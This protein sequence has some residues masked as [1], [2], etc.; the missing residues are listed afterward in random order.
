[1]SSS[2]EL[3]LS[4]S[5]TSLRELIQY[6]GVDDR[7]LEAAERLFGEIAERA[8]LFLIALAPFLEPFA[9]SMNSLAEEPEA[10]GY[11]RFFIE[12]L[13][14][15]PL[16]ARLMTRC[17]RRSNSRLSGAALKTGTNFAANS[18][19]PECGAMDPVNAASRRR[20]WPK[21]SVYRDRSPAKI[22]RRDRWRC[23]IACSPTQNI[24]RSGRQ[25]R[26]ISADSHRRQ[27]RVRCIAWVIFWRTK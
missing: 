23:S 24:Q 12:W 19:R 2:Q 9:A 3:G 4:I 11:E 13:G 25:A 1:M 18:W 8:E 5:Q 7:K 26:R 6:F 20:R 22:G 15:H 16:V 21:A 10:P 27:Q 17:G 14:Y